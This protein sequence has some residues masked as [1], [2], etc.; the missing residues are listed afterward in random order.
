MKK[1]LLFIL[2]L[3]IMPNKIHALDNINILYYKKIDNC[4][5]TS[6]IDK[7]LFYMQMY[8]LKENNYHTITLDE[9]IKW[10]DN[11]L[12]LDDK[13]ILLL[14]Q[15]DNEEV[16][17]FITFFDFKI[18]N[19]GEYQ[20]LFKNNMISSKKDEDILNIST[21][22]IKSNIDIDEFKKII[23]GNNLSKEYNMDELAE[24]IPVLNYH[25]LYQTPGEC[26]EI[27]CL[28]TAK[29]EEQ[30]QYLND[31]NYKTLSIDEFVKWKNNEI[32]LPKKSVL[33]TFDDGGYGT[34]NL[35]GNY[36]INLIEKYNVKATLF[37]VTGFWNVENY[38]SPNLDVQTH[39]NNMH[40]EYSEGYALEYS[41]SDGIKNDLLKSLETI[42]N[43]KSFAYPF[44]YYDDHAINVL[45]ELGFKVA[46]AG[47]NFDVTRYSNN[48]TLP[49]YVILS[50][51][52]LE[53]FIDIIE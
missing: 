10:R 12:E 31:N 11:K 26:N 23:N 4:E 17:K 41:S 36:L 22:F 30:L 20:T 7:D 50:D 44:Y 51:I 19:L 9:F 38:I 45:K 1:L 6:C 21:Y 2:L 35:T 13:A 8:Y 3:I 28:S 34:S 40:I 39:T 25:F 15:E 27:I 14:L 48:Y 46:F 32:E 29:F 53:D 42:K 16:K 37:L 52:T 49:R 18:N 47:G 5:L 24:E 33:I 43:N